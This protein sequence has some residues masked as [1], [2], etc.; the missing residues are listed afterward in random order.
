M[1]WAWLKHNVEEVG[2]LGTSFLV[3]TTATRQ[4]GLQKR[5]RA[6]RATPE[7]DV[8]SVRPPP[9]WVLGKLKQ[10]RHCLHVGPVAMDSRR[11]RTPFGHRNQRDQALPHLTVHSSQ[12]HPGRLP[13]PGSN[14]L[15]LPDEDDPAPGRRPSGRED[16]ETGLRHAS[17]GSFPRRSLE[18]LVVS[19]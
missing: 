18:Y 12:T 6:M 9:R 14:H 15:Y 8:R 16:V 11:A 4:G 13:H 2:N 17:T 3:S 19:P 10:L 5:P 1:G 7:L